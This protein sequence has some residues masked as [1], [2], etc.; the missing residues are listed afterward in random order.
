MTDKEGERKNTKMQKGGKL[1]EA[2]ATP[3]GVGMA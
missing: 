3:F 2:S 1:T